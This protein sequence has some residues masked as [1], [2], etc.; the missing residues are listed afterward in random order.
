MAMMP[1]IKKLLAQPTSASKVGLRRESAHTPTINVMQEDALRAVLMENPND[2]NAFRAL[3]ELVKRNC[4]SDSENSADP[5]KAES[6]GEEPVL[7]PQDY[8]ARANLSVWALAEEL[9]GHPKAWFPVIELARLSLD[10]SPGEALRRLTAAVSR[11][12]SGRALERSIELLLDKGLA[13]EAYNLGLG[14]WRPNDHPAETGISVV[15]AALVS[16]RSLDAQR[17]YNKLIEHSG[18]DEVRAL[19]PDLEKEIEELHADSR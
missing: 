2:E 14:L 19:D 1:R 4:A 17:E 6:T 5:L 11:D 15:R 7:D 8:E 16:Q 18:A 12:P 13:S 9:S 3:V 10:E